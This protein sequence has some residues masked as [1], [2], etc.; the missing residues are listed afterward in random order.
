[1]IGHT[2]VRAYGLLALPPW[3]KPIA[4]LNCELKFRVPAKKN[5]FGYFNLNEIGKS[6]QNCKKTTKTC[7]ETK[8]S[9]GSLDSR[10]I[11]GL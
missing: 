6:E 2:A 8:D 3:S 5:Y 1:M 10:H 7:I 4:S 11:L 9:V